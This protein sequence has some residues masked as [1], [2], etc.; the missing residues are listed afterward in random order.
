M[1]ENAVSCGC[2][3]PGNEHVEPR[4][5]LGQQG[6]AGRAQTALDAVAHNGA[7][8]L[9]AHGKADLERA[10]TRIEH[11][12]LMR[13]AGRAAA[14]D[15]FELRVLFQA[16]RSLQGLLRPLCGRCPL[17]LPNCLI[18]LSSPVLVA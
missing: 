2:T 1:Q 3:L 16:I 15:I 13:A 5:H 12:H 9:L 6:R 11:D 4:L 14:I 7:A 17:P 10:R 18:T 8:Q